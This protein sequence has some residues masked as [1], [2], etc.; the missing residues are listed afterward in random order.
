MAWESV[1]PIRV[2]TIRVG[3]IQSP[4]LRCKLYRDV[5]PLYEAR[6]PGLALSFRKRQEGGP[7]YFIRQQFR[8]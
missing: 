7:D 6:R 4:A 8:G 1:G 5:A 3:R 2:I